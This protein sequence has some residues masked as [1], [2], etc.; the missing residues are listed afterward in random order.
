MKNLTCV[1]AIL[2]GIVLFSGGLL[3]QTQET[4]RSLSPFNG[5]KVSNSI[6]ATLVKGDKHEISIIA[7]A[8]ELEKVESKVKDRILELS[9][10]GTS[11]RASSV[12]A[13]ITYVEI[14]EVHANTNAKVFVKDPISAKAVTITTATSAYVEAEVKAQQLDLDAQTNSRM[15]LKGETEQLNFQLFTN[16]EINA[17]GLTAVHADI[18]ANTN[19]KGEFSVKE[20]VKG[21]AATRGR[22]TYFGDP[23]VVDVKTNTGGAIDGN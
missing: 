21:T 6:E 8:V 5:V 2:L 23:N 18:R 16:A 14:E 3:A 15:S 20:S 17:K 13:T 7:T 10:S 12:K 9:I 11:P 22:V 19:S 1:S 4:T